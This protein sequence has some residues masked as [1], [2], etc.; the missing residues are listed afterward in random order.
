M[1]S[2][3]KHIAI[4]ISI[5]LTILY[6]AIL[7]CILLLTSALTV[8]GLYYVLY[9]QADDDIIL[10]ANSVTR[11]LAA[12]KP[13]NQHLLEANLIV[14]GVMLRVFDEQNRLVID[15]APYAPGNRV[16]SEEDE[17]DIN[18]LKFFPLKRRILHIAHIDHN[19]FF[20]ATQA[21]WNNDHVYLLHFM[22]TMSEQTH[23]LKTLIKSL[24]ITNAIGLFIAVI[25][26]IYISRKILCPI[27]DITDTAKEIEINDL[28]KRI[29]ATGGNDEL[30]ELARTFNHMLN[31]IQTGF[32]QQ[33]RFVA[34]ASHEL[35]TPI[36]VISGYADMLDRWGKQDPAALE[37]GIGAIKSEAANMHGLIEKL[38]FLARTD[39]NKQIIN[40]T[41][42]AMGPLIAEIV[43][44]TRLIAPSHQIELH[45]NDPVTVYAD[46]AS[47]KEMLRIFIENSIKYTPAG[48][49]ISLTSQNT[50]HHLDIT[51][52]DTGIG[53][54]EEE[55]SKIF[56]R[57]Y[58]VDKSRSKATGGTGL[59]L[60]IAQWIAK[61]HSSSIQL[62]SSPGT[63]TSVTVKIPLIASEK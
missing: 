16:L 28:G 23:F 17:E 55:Q 51:I 3:I 38:L 31:R 6:S 45:K 15:N 62:T 54:P 7:S 8:A 36:T 50:G 11:Y 1:W 59:G 18:P 26:G 13:L 44:E 5:K 21:V 53:I 34:N 56:D 33:R 48:G 41:A 4:P 37:E 22:R 49:T 10:S 25:S 40:K 24:L 47:L 52:Q 63:G 61:Q 12:G 58:R 32:D 14:P 57:F 46:P 27:R 19:Y 9:T 29:K 39:Q 30:Q 42:V 35:R 2:R 20:Y 60:S 43:Q